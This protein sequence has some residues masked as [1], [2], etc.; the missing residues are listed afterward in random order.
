MIFWQEDGQGGAAGQCSSV[1]ATLILFP[2]AGVFAHGW[3]WLKHAD[4]D[5]RLAAST[6]AES[7]E[8]EHR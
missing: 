3:R 2:K 1:R 8:E 4:A 5:R 6:R 7:L